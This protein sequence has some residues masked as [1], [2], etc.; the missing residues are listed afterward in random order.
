MAEF[1]EIENIKDVEISEQVKKLFLDYSMSVIVARAI[2]SVSDGLKPV[3]RRIIYSMY[4]SGRTHDKPFVKS[5]RAVGDTLGRFHPHGDSSVYG[6]MVRLAQPF[7][8]RY[9]LIDGH[10]NFGSLDG[11]EAAAYR[12][13]EVRLTKLSSQLVRD[14]EFDVVKF[15]SNYDGMNQEPVELP[16]RFPNLLVNGSSGIAVGMATNIPP[17]NLTETIDAVI[18]LAKNPNL[19]INEIMQYLHGPDFPTGG[20]ILGIAGIK[21]AYE[22]GTGSIIIRSKY[23][24]EQDNKKKV[25]VIDEIPYGVNKAELVK[26]IS[27]LAKETIDGI[28]KINDESNI[29]GIRIAIHIRVDCIPEIILNKLFSLTKLQTS[30]SIIFLC[31]KHNIPKIMPIKTILNSYLDHQ[32][33]VITKRTL[34][35]KNRDN[36]RKNIINGLFI[37]IKNIN[38]VIKIISSG[39]TFEEIE[40]QLSKTYNLSNEQIQAILSMTLK[41]LSGLEQEKLLEELSD[42][43]ERLLSYENILKNRDNKIKVIIDELEEIKREF[44]DNRRTEITDINWEINEEDMIPQRDIVVAITEKGY[45]KRTDLD[46]FRQ[47]NV[48]GIGSKGM[49]VT[50][51]DVIKLFINANTHSNLLFF[52][53]IGKVYRIK[54]YKIQEGNKTS[55]GIPVQNFFDLNKEKHEKIVSIVKQDDTKNLTFVTKNG[56]IKQTKLKEYQRIN[57]TGKIAIKL[58]DNDDLFDVK[59]TDGNNLICLI[60]KYGKAVVFDSQ[61]LRTTARNTK[62]VKGVKLSNKDDEVIGFCT[63]SEGTTILVITE[64]GYGK[65]TDIGKYKVTR[66]PAR[67]VKTIK[68]TKKNGFLV[69]AKIVHGNEDLMA[70]TTKGTVI[71]V[72][73]SDLKL[74]NRVAQ[75]TRLIDLKNYKQAQKVSSVTIYSEEND[76]LNN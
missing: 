64:N 59:C 48:G 62:G 5:V 61:S 50:D 43:K 14:I 65:M 35:L 16:A 47:Q 46:L 69:S 41:R 18:A 19:T 25:I 11:D 68:I 28:T 4:L 2:P 67:G 71:R 40:Q 8:M 24:F 73:L 20:I 7:S 57:K 55:K 33:E 66:R 76:I 74:M 42:I 56:L 39:T 27:L 54:G 15:M 6:A 31:L 36:H 63:S 75:G 12:Y 13:T 29:K 49:N 30:F 72:T 44:G 51:D 26:S 70:I 34:F 52:S 60:T 10:G 21:R 22:T 1:P 9:P 23:H 58:N 38:N 53:S 3:Q 45:I 37:A 17:H 32:I